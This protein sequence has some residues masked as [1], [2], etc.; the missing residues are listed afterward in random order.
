MDHGVLVLDIIGFIVGLLLVEVTLLLGGA[1]REVPVSRLI[2]RLL[3][4]TLW[5]GAFLILVT[6]VQVLTSALTYS[7]T[8]A[9]TLAIGAV[10]LVVSVVLFWFFADGYR[11]IAD[12]EG[13]SQ[14]LSL[15]LAWVVWGFLATTVLVRIG[16]FDANVGLFLGAFMLLGVLVAI[17]SR[18]R[19]PS[20][21]TILRVP[22]VAVGVSLLLGFAVAFVSHTATLNIELGS[23][24]QPTL[25]TVG[26]GS[27][28]VLTATSL[29][30]GLL[31]SGLGQT[32]K[33]LR[34]NFRGFLR[35]TKP[36]FH[37]LVTLTIHGRFGGSRTQSLL[38]RA[39]GVPQPGGSLNLVSSRLTLVFH[40]PPLKTTGSA[41]TVLADAAFGTLK[42]HHREYT[43]L[44]SYE[45][46]GLYLVSG[47]ITLWPRSPQIG[48]AALE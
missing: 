16:T 4:S 13:R 25:A 28:G 47:S 39:R 11:S 40:S 35:V 19:L 3:T 17:T 23:G 30:E 33:V 42:L 46:T 45:P 21:R 44:L 9:L 38:F 27:P 41:N 6:P 8:T 18:L 37:Q 48:H 1:P 29:R 10:V 32:D 34:L 14:R 12:R 43:Y 15:L 5:L 26:S 24:Q 7:H 20:L 36:N 22:A 2:G 31:T